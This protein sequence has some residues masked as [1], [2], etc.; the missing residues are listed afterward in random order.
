[1]DKNEI[2]HLINIKSE[3]VSCEANCGKLSSDVWK[4]F[5]RVKIDNAFCD[6]VKC[7]NCHKALKWRSRDGTHG[8]KIHVEYCKKL[9]SS[10]KLFDLPG[11]VCG[12][13]PHLP[14]TVK[15]EIADTVVKT[16]ARDIRPFKFVEGE[17]FAQLAD[18]LISIGAK[19]GNVAAADILPSATTVSRHLAEVVVAEKDKLLPQLR[20]IGQFGV[21]TDMWTHF[22]TNDSYITVTVQFINDK[23]E[24]MS[25]VLATRVVDE[26]HTGNCIRDHV[27]QI[28]VEFESWH[29]TN[30]FVTDNA[31]N[32]KSAFRDLTWI[33]CAC[34]N[35]NLVLSHGLTPSSD[36]A[37]AGPCLPAT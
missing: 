25:M 22:K 16:C 10:R 19:Y 30:V 20:S 14:A 28:L 17:G 29:S 1:M 23:W 6:Y 37:A 4:Q 18:K 26:S 9:T 8:L 35:L 21:T 36:E 5:V 7:T 31:A 12:N 32:M 2:Q 27:K 13:K 15:S 3:R 34:H 11:V 24:L 33:G